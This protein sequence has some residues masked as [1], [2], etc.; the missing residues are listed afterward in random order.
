MKK[1]LSYI[2]IIICVIQQSLAQN[3]VPVP[4]YVTKPDSAKPL[5]WKNIGSITSPENLANEREHLIRILHERASASSILMVQPKLSSASTRRL[6][7][8][9]PTLYA[10]TSTEYA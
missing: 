1:T 4:L 9:K 7:T 8:T 6:P 2:A 3:L 10:L 5:V